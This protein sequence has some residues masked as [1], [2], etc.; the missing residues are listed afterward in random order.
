MSAQPKGT[1]P[2]VP[3]VELEIDGHPVTAPKGS[4]I[5]TAA[6]AASIP[7]PRFCYHKKLP[8]AAVCRQGMVEVD[9]NGKTMPKPQVACATPFAAGMKVFTKSERA[10]HAQQNALEFVLINHPLD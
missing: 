2:P 5:I 1:T 4:T 6:D 9:M 10:I 3:M 8:I 7:L